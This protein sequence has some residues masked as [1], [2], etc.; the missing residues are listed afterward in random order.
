VIDAKEHKWLEIMHIKI[1]EDFSDCDLKFL[2]DHLTLLDS[3]WDEIQ[4]RIDECTDPESAGLFDEGEYLVG[5]GFTACQQYLSATYGPLGVKKEAALTV[6][7][8][9]TSGQTYARLLNAAANYWKHMEEWDSIA[10]IA[11][12]VDALKKIQKQ[13]V[14][15]I[16]FV[17]PWSDYTCANLLFELTIPELRLSSLIPKL[18]D[19]RRQLD[20]AYS[21]TNRSILRGEV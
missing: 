6:G 11:R 15:I 16:E 13:T 2:R 8:H 21:G 4:K 5:M 12:N 3:R 20:A 7:P 14:R 18:E 10:V 19:W 1:G 17:T 9:H